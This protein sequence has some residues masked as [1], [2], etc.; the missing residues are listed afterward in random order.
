MEQQRVVITGLGAIA[1]NGVGTAAFWD[2]LI[3]GRSG[4][5]P[6]RRFDASAFPS[7]IAGEVRDFEPPACLSI[8]DLRHMSR[9]SQF[10]V[11]VSHM[12]VEDAGIQ[13]TTDNS[14][15]IGVCFGTSVGKSEAVDDEHLPFLH[16]GVRAIHPTSLL[17]F[18]PH[19]V[20]SHVA[21]ALDLRGV[22]GT[23]S[24][25]CTGGLETVQWG[26]HQI[27]QGRAA[28][29]VVGGTEALL[30]PYAFGMACAAGLLSTRN[31]APQAASRPFE[32]QRDGLV[33]SEGAGALVL[34]AYEHARARQAPMYAEVLGFS[35]AR[36][37]RQL[38]G[39]DASG[40]SIV[41]VIEDALA[42][43]ALPKHRLDYICAHGI[44]LGAYD[45]AE[46][47]AIKA[48]FGAHAYN[49]PVSSIK[50]MIGQPFSAASAL[51]TV[52]A[53][54]VLQ[55]GVIPPT[56]NL[57]TPDPQCDLDYVP[58][59]ARRARVRTVLVQACGMG[60]TYSTLLLGEVTS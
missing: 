14:S 12:A 56:I 28:V 10:A 3:H 54:L 16:K 27:R 2:A 29:A 47:N 6:I 48:V 4:I 55:H 36:E 38:V 26:C 30:T 44:A 42:R 13:L 32:A 52:A 5:S 35:T 11:G 57:D 7:R 37:G 49:T 45:V 19:A 41:R 60:G 40:R 18:A 21:A 33:F 46:T 15:S 50:S 23:L 53:C 22:S 34:E 51:Q 8:R 31:Q 20:S 59:R 25:G 17:E 24:S 1:P 9:A 58:H 39:V 43:A